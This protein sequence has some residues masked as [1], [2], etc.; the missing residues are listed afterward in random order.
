MRPRPFLFA[1]TGVLLGAAV[2]S[3]AEPAAVHAEFLRAIMD[4]PSLSAAARRTSAARERTEASGRLADPE[5]EGMTSRLNGPMGERRTMYELNLRQ[6]LPKRGER[7]ADRERAR[8]GV[9]MADA[10]YFL[11]AG[12]LAA[13]TAMALAE[14]DGASRRIRLLET[15]LGRLDAVLR[16]LEVRLAA[17][18]TGRMADRLTVQTRIASMQL[19][20]EEER[21]MAA[22]ALAAA[23]GRLGLAPEAPL[24]AFAA[25][26]VA[27]IKADEAA[28]L[29]LAAARSDEASA[30]VKMARASANPMTAVGLRL[31]KEKTLMG[32]ENTVGLAFMSEIPWRSRGYARAEA[33]AAEA[34][35]AAAQTDGAAAR[36][37]IT[38]ALTRVD[39]AER[40]AATARRLSAETL[41]RLDAEYDAMIRAA[42]AGTPE[43][44]TVLQTVELLEKATD[45]DSQIIRADTA[46]LNA[47]AE[48]WRFL[49][50]DLFP[51]ATK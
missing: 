38:A 21:Q 32:D 42:G 47:R 41:R 14:A 10:D 27:D 17:G 12:E 45:T 49:P 50:T 25:P 18:V 40:L 5:V 13:D 7:A 34:E 15:Q 3:A 46:V 44:S 36:F 43:G 33:R 29:R 22:D 11:M 16:S 37:R 30:M 31:G 20:I 26:T 39:R 1:L 24:P 9:A 19:M 23:R 4:A 28:A 6:P 48:L 51:T 8:A 2:L 35:R